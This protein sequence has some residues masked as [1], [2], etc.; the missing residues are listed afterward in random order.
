MA[1]S[2]LKVTTL[3]ATT[4]AVVS[5]AGVGVIVTVNVPVPSL[6]AA[7]PAVAV[8]TLVVSAVTAAAVKIFVAT[9]KLPPF[10]QVT[11]GPDVT[12]NASLAVRT[13]EPVISDS[14]ESVIGLNATVGAA[15]S[16]GA[17]IVT[18]SVA[19]PELPAASLAVAV[20]TLVASTV[21]VAAVNTF[22]PTLKLPP[23]VQVTVGPDVT[24]MASV[25]VNVELPVWADSTV[26]VVALKATTGAVV[27]TTGGTT[28]GFTLP[29]PPP[30]PQADK[31][32]ADAIEREERG[33]FLK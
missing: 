2:T 10:V 4:G 21:I 11:V 8:H 15:V 5:G 9:S 18:V 27:S 22:V 14:T 16:T 20:H 30:P 3:N 26:K 7:S 19:V 12:P 1:D 33:C 31:S 29:P 25:A 13:D 28:G 32:S 23:L 24:P 17:I 6:P